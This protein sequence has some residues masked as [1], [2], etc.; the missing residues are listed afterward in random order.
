MEKE[1]AGVNV[2]VNTGKSVQAVSSKAVTNYDKMIAISANALTNIALASVPD[3]VQQAINNAITEAVNLSLSSGLLQTIIND[4]ENLDSGIYKKTYIDNKVS[5]IEN[6]AIQKASP[7]LVASVADSKVAL[8]IENLATTS[9]VSALNGRVDNSETSIYNLSQTVNTKDLAR[10]EQINEL[11]ASIDETFAGY[12][13]A[14]DLYVDAQGNVKSMKI[15]SL[16]AQ[17]NTVQVSIDE[18]NQIVIDENG[19]YTASVAKMIKDSN[20][21]IVG[22][23]FANSNGMTSFVITADLIKIKTANGTLTPFSLQGNELSLNAKVSFSNVTGFDGADV[24]N[25]FNMI[26]NSEFTSN[27]QPWALGYNPNG[28]IIANFGL[29]EDI[30]G[31][32]WII[33]GRTGSLTVY[34]S[35]RN[36]SIANDDIGV[37]IYPQGAWDSAKA[38]SIVAGESYEFSVYIAAHRCKASIGIAYYKAD[39]TQ[40]AYYQSNVISPSDGGKSIS[41]YTRLHLRTIAPADASLA[42]L[43]TRK[44]NTDVG[45]T[46]SWFWVAR[47]FFGKVNSSSTAPIDY[48]ASDSVDSLYTAGTTKING[49]YVDTYS[50]TADKI[51]SY[52]L[53]AQNAIIG[54]AIIGNAQIQDGSINNAKIENLSVNNAKIADASIT[55]AK[56]GDLSVSTFKI[57]DEA[58]IVPRFAGGIGSCTIV[59]T[60]TTSHSIVLIAYGGSLS[61]ARWTNRK[62]YLNGSLQ[63]NKPQDTYVHGS[64]FY[65]DQFSFY[66]W[67]GTTYTFTFESIGVFDGDGSSTINLETKLTMLGVK[68]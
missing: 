24:N 67:A 45:Q 34:Q 61:G 58:V 3:I 35:N 23:Q 57:Q 5:Y 19:T 33:S 8:A 10:A 39:G 44:H 29:S 2:I 56:I 46:N 20:G 9:Q 63:S 55:N 18:N 38:Y 11:E 64:G 41:N 12:S 28:S 53:T 49:G 22:F 65:C 21:N 52:N 60:P 15:E 42:L 43:H 50:I 54:N 13:D 4:I 36:T 17:S 68:K 16:E 31:A 48:I 27:I 1:I 6:M 37:D 25:S 7:E 40:V 47:P 51:A 32:D 59:Y 62:L 26:K 30:L 14:I 66:L